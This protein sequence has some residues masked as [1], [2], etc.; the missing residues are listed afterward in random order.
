MV[1]RPVTEVWETS[2]GRK[3]KICDMEN[4]HLL[5]A[6]VFCRRKHQAKIE[7]LR[8]A[9]ESVSFNAN[10]NFDRETKL[11]EA[12]EVES[13]HPLYDFLI[14]EAERR[15]LDYEKYCTQAASL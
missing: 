11:A 3:I 2:D 8:A 7:A 1:E 12:E 14:I 9:I 6:I 15:G 13:D 4:S 5:N 10:A